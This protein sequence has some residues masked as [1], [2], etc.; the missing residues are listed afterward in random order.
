[1]ARSIDLAERRTRVMHKT[2][3]DVEALPGDDAAKTLS[4]LAALSDA[5]DDNAD[6]L[7][8]A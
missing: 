4:G 5:V 2:L 8:A 7:P 1:V 3:R 6:A